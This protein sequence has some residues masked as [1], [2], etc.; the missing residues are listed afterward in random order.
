M[1]KYYRFFIIMHVFVGIG[2]L[3][4]GL[5]GMLDPHEPLGIPAAHLEGSPFSSYFVP[6][7]IL[8]L[9]IGLGHTFS[10]IT[11]YKR[12]PYQAY[13]SS[14]F[15]WALMIWIGV[16]CIMMGLIDFLHVLYFLI[17]LTGAVMAMRMLF[18]QGLFPSGVFAWHGAE[19]LMR[20]AEDNDRSDG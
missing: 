7:L 13:I 10:A 6:S 19:N 11:A 1:N 12:L 20:G 17:G 3:F 4:G 9:V 14:V 2:A 5:A 15:S 8:F 18:R 16:Q